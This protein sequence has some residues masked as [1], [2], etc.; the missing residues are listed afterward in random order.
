MDSSH[1]FRHDKYLTKIIEHTVGKE[2]VLQE[3]D[4][5]DN[6]TRDVCTPVKRI[7]KLEENGY[8][9]TSN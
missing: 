2:K 1:L 9:E 7:W 4:Y 8:S 6:T 3:E 5:F